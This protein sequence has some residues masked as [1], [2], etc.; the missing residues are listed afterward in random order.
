MTPDESPATVAAAEKLSGTAATA[1]AASAAASEQRP[2]RKQKRGKRILIRGE[3]PK[4]KGPPRKKPHYTQVVGHTG[5]KVGL[6]FDETYH[7]KFVELFAQYGLTDAE[8][9]A[10]FDISGVTFNAWRKKYKLFAEAL[11]RGRLPTNALLT[12]AL[13][14]KGLGYEYEETEFAV[15]RVTKERVPVS[16]KT[17]HQ[18]PDVAAIMQFLKNRSGGKWSDKTSVEHSGSTGTEI[19]QLIICVAPSEMPQ[20]KVVSDAAP[21]RTIKAAPS[22]GTGDSSA[23]EPKKQPPAAPVLTV[24]VSE[25]ELPQAATAPAP[26]PP[27]ANLSDLDDALKGL[28]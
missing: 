12:G 11:E 20:P 17:K 7:I 8:I 3:K 24:A 6:K 16:I 14:K 2:K 4:K 25:S 21:V 19:K 15:N 22:V 23:P 18:P 1:S 9:C 13:V 10:D 26:E 5:N 27:G 28:T